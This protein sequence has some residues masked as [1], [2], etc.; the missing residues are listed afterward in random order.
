M[1]EAALGAT[2]DN[3]AY[4]RCHN[5]QRYDFTPGGS[6]GGSA[7]AVAA[8]LCAAALGTDTLGSVRVPASYCGCYGFKASSGLISN[9]GVV[10]LSWTL[11]HVG[12]ITLCAE[13]LPLLFNQLADYDPYCAGSRQLPS[14]SR[15]ETMTLRIG[16]I[17]RL[18]QRVEL[19]PCVQQMFNAVLEKLAQSGL[20]LYAVPLPDYDFTRMRRA[21]LLI[22]EAEGAVVHAEGIAA[23]PDGY[24]SA[25]RSMLAWGAAQSA[26]RLA[27]AYHERNR[28]VLSARRL[29]TE[30]DV[31]VLPT[32]PQSTFPFAQQ[33]PV[34]QADL[35]SFASLARCP[36]LSLPMG[37]SRDGLPLGL[38]LVGAELADRLLLE[39]PRLLPALTVG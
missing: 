30:I 35:T 3:P 17:D 9:R 26:L 39:V 31:L 38:Q 24:S 11:D 10:P 37:C 25:L 22:S 16:Y 20:Q 1:H 19:E 14:A 28:V 4:G 8:G 32:T 23:N 33:V 18:E 13:D 12:P 6:S 36:A 29:F 34:N 5:P 15:P 7:A 2:T 21:G 27:Q